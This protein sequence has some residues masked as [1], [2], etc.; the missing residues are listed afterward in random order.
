MKVAV[1]HGVD[2]YNKG[3]KEDVHAKTIHT[4]EAT[5]ALTLM[6]PKTVKGVA[7]VRY[8]KTVPDEDFLSIEGDDGRAMAKDWSK[9]IVAHPNSSSRDR[10]VRNERR[11]IRE[12]VVRG[13]GV[14]NQQGGLVGVSGMG[15]DI[16]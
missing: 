8:V 4:N 13:A 11:F 15:Y 16:L 2:F 10:M 6:G 12:H 5:T 3:W 1:G 7:Q 9:G 14:C